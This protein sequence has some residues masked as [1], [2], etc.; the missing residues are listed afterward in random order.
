MEAKNSTSPQTVPSTEHFSQQ[1]VERNHDD[2]AENE[3]FFAIVMPSPFI[4]GDI[5]DMEPPLST[6]DG[7]GD[8]VQSNESK[9]YHRLLHLL[10]KGLGDAGDSFVPYVAQP[11]GRT[12]RPHA[13]ISVRCSTEKLAELAESARLELRQTEQCG[14]GYWPFMRAATHAAQFEE[15]GCRTTKSR[16]HH[17]NG[18]K[19]QTMTQRQIRNLFTPAQKQSLVK[20]V[21]DRIFDEF[22]QSRHG[23]GLFEVFG[24][25]WVS[26][27]AYDNF[28]CV[29]QVCMSH[30]EKVHSLMFSPCTPSPKTR[31]PKRDCIHRVE[32]S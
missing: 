14:G 32:G 5:A 15:A 29:P 13:F 21:L 2:G 7:F 27:M 30:S 31:V 9:N 11:C 18:D 22:S 20:V 3:F 6:S 23:R 25:A 10:E 12:D 28:L 16:R 4:D 17:H 19:G 26:S 24:S 8:D 1:V